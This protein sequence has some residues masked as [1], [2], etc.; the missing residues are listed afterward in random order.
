M[1]PEAA[2]P[3]IR[4]CELAGVSRAT[5]YAQRTLKPTS[6]HDLAL[7]GL[8]DEQYTRRPFY[9]SPKMVS[10]LKVRGHWVNRKRVKRLMRILGLAG[11][12][13][14]AQHQPP[15]SAAQGVSVPVA[16]CGG[17]KTEPGVEY[18]H[19]LHPAGAWLRLLGF[20]FWLVLSDSR[21]KMSL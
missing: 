19:H 9:G 8:I 10:F 20:N 17:H 3:V 14:G 2:L 6:E 16:R 21:N 11:M 12:A 7:L 4:Q 1:E 5:V 18:G 15:V 13:P